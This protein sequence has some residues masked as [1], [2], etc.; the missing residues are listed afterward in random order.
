M[1]INKNH[2]VFLWEKYRYFNIIPGCVYRK[3]CTAQC[4][5]LL[6][7]I[8]LPC[9][10]LKPAIIS[11]ENLPCLNFSSYFC[12]F[13]YCLI[14]TTY[15][16]LQNHNYVAISLERVNQQRLIVRQLNSKFMHI[17]KPEFP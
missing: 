4:S 15:F 2:N 7:Y 1:R 17:M 10:H 8:T 12:A 9:T 13:L 16:F 11:S 5:A 6:V 3:D 14:S